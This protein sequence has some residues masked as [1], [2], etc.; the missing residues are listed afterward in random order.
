DQLKEEGE[1]YKWQIKAYA[2]LLSRLY[3][4]QEKY[5]VSLYFLLPDRLY[6]KVFTKQEVEKTAQLFLDTIQEIKDKI[7]VE[8][9]FHL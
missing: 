6:S 2:L 5:P 8:L 9:V 3:P 7:P 4:E 1:K